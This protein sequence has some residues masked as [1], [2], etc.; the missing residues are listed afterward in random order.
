[1][2]GAGIIVPTDD[3]KRLCS[4]QESGRR[5]NDIIRL[6]IGWHYYL[7]HEQGLNPGVA[8]RNNDGAL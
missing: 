6:A 2:P 4:L 5:A 8:F 7:L 3:G 1:M